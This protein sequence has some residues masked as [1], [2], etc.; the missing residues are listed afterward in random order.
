MSIIE[1]SSALVVQ[2]KSTRE[3]ERESILME[4]LERIRV[5]TILLVK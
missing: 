4:V 2:S 1:D 5:V 3:R